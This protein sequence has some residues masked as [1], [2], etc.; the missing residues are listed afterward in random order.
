VYI[1]D[2]GHFE[3]L[4]IYELARRRC[5]LIVACDSEEDHDFTF[6]GLGNAIRKCR[7]DLGVDI[8]IDLRPLLDRDES[9]RTSAHVLRGS[10]DYHDGKEPGVLLYLKS[11]L[12]KPALHPEPADVLEYAMRGNAFPHQSTADQFFDESQFES[13]RRLGMHIGEDAIEKLRQEH[14]I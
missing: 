14:I 5:R 3:N 10:I 11:S 8:D 2:G 7:I 1:S 9:D 13:Y 4:G 6:G 12:T